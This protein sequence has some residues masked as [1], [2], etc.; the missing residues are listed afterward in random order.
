MAKEI[1]VVLGS[2][3]S[4]TGEL[5]TISKERVDF[6]LEIYQKEMLVLCT[7]SWGAHFNTASEPHAFYIKNYLIEKGI[8]EDRFLE[9]A[10]S[11]NTVEDAV[12]T[13]DIISVLENIQVTIITSDYHLERVKL[14]FNEV[15]KEYKL[16]FFGVKSN[17][18][19]EEYSAL[20]KH[21]KKA[22][23]EIIKN[24]LYY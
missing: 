9:F 5:S 11:T 19:Q 21:E 22:I 13:R 24:G 14:I 1:L 20:V 2:P 6:C 23:A 16:T 3:N 15:L 8:P 17:F 4:P 18:E 7:G 12:K 10:L